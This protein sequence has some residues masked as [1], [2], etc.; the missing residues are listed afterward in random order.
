MLQNGGFRRMCCPFSVNARILRAPVIELCF[1]WNWIVILL[2]YMSVVIK[3]APIEGK[4]VVD[5]YYEVLCPDSRAFLLYQVLYFHIT[6][7]WSWWKQLAVNVISWLYIQLTPAWI[8]LENIFTVNFIPY[9]K[10]QVSTLQAKF[11]TWLLL[12]RPTEKEAAS[13]SHASMVQSNARYVT[14]ISRDVGMLRWQDVCF[15][16]LVE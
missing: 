5:V 7:L 2:Y 1:V 12:W 3:G 4:L 9:G 8:H 14:R 6:H 11:A 15:F 16:A 10:A 13:L